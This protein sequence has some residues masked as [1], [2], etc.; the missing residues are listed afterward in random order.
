MC[1]KLLTALFKVPEAASLKAGFYTLN[2]DDHNAA[3]DLL[4]YTPNKR[5]PVRGALL[6]A[7]FSDH[8]D[9]LFLQE[10]GRYPDNFLAYASYINVVSMIKEGS[11]GK[12]EIQDMLHKLL[13]IARGR[14]GS[15]DGNS[16]LLAALCVAYAKTG[17]MKSGKD[18]LL[19]MLNLF[20][21][22]AET[23]FAF[24]IYN[25]ENY[26]ASG[27]AIADDIRSRLR[28]IFMRY[29]DAELSKDDI[30]WDYLQDDRTI[31][32]RAFERV[33]GPAYKNGTISYYRLN[34]LPEIYISRKLKARKAELLLKKEL[35]YFQDGRVNH[36]ERI[37]DAQYQLYVP[38]TLLDLAKVAVLQKNYS[39]A[40]VHASAA[41]QIIGGS[42]TADNFKRSILSVRANSYKLAG[43]YTRALNDYVS[44]YRDADPAALDSLRKLFKEYNITQ[45]SFATFLSSIARKGEI[46][47]DPDVPPITDFHCTAL[48]G[49]QVQLAD[50]KGKIIVI[51][52]WSIGCAPC[53]AEIPELNQ[54]VDGY[55]NRSDIVFL[56][57][58][59]DKKQRVDYFLDNRIFK[60]KILN[61]EGNLSKQ[62]NTNVLP[63]HIVIGKSGEILHQSV[64]ARVDIRV[65][66]REVIE[67]HSGGS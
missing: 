28:E 21:A 65:S 53:V 25:Y 4:V 8:P 34:Q 35:K 58:T 57:I 45:D 40:I 32:V 17:D 16:G 38:L 6:Q 47:A 51:N 33:S 10:I 62:F 31:P 26:K 3:I 66:L 48:D 55:R 22:S 59:A 44:L 52:L 5:T 18:Y 37:T 11:E 39:S 7:F 64:G 19:R 67:S 1:G 42:S 2:K 15:P 30:I 12:K 41:L 50:F 23:R 49:S 13:E 54:L 9:S 43:D 61:F 56:A 14:K 24:T 63:V 36:E 29:P 60:Y 46:H 27:K 20:P